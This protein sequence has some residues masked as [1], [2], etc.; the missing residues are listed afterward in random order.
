MS[1]LHLSSRTARNF[2]LLLLLGLGFF[3]LSS[4]TKTVVQQVNQVFSATYSIK[5]SDWV[6]DNSGLFYYRTDLSV[7][8]ID[9][10][11]VQQGAVLAYVSFD[12]GVSFD[13][14]PETING[15]TY[16]ALHEAGKLT[17]GYYNAANIA[18]P[19]SLPGS[20]VLIKVVILDAKPL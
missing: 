6:K 4:C 2:S 1:Q 20:T 9:N 12:N 10:T 15:I 7:P 8:E 11:I 3:T 17:I 18:T 13:A 16:N 19:V 5:T 14:V